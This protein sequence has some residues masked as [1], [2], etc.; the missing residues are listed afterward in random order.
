LLVLGVILGSWISA[1][2]A[3]EFEIEWPKPRVAVGA[4]IGGVFL[5]WGATVA[6]GCTVGT[7]LSGIQVSAASGWI[8]AATMLIGLLVS[9]PLRNRWIIP[10]Q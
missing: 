3:R 4:W 5:G 6:A 7:L 2:A 8:F 10:R 1:L 9:L